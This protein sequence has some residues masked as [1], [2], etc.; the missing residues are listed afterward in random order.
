[1]YDSSNKE[2]MAAAAPQRDIM[3]IIDAQKQM[4]YKFM[5]PVEN[6]FDALGMMSGPAAP[7]LRAGTGFALGALVM[8]ALRPEFAFDPETGRPLTR[9]ETS[10][11]WYLPPLA[12]GFV[13]GTFV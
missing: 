13:F 6:I 5:E 3:K 4:P 2:K 12:L 8:Q 1:V 7:L 10:C 9:K 11:P